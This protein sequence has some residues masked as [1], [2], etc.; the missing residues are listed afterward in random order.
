MKSCWTQAYLLSARCPVD[1]VQEEQP[2]RARYAQAVAQARRK[3][4]FEY[5]DYTGMAPRRA[6]HAWP[7]GRDPALVFDPAGAPLL[8]DP[9]RHELPADK[10]GTVERPA[11]HQI[12]CVLGRGD[13]E[14][15]A[16]TLVE[17]IR[18][19]EPQQLR[20]NRGRH[21]VG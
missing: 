18:L 4:L 16:R 8:L 7:C 6:P 9:T 10:H 13:H 19:T 15:G 2:I 20:G 1:G 12:L 21:G 17:A 3:R 11:G 14:I 5:F